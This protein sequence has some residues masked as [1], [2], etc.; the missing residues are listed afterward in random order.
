LI[1][2]LEGR[3]IQTDGM[4]LHGQG[5]GYSVYVIDP[6]GNRIELSKD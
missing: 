4:R 2:E 5:P 6:G 1:A 3:G